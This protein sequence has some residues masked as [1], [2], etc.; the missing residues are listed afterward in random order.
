[1]PGI[2]GNKDDRGNE[3]ADDWGR[4]FKGDVPPRMRELLV[5]RGRDGATP[6]KGNRQRDRG[7]GFKADAEEK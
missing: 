3:E 6:S 7:G 1:M 5:E 2:L 4:R